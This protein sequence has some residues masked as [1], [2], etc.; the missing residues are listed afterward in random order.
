MRDSAQQR[1]ETSSACSQ[2]IDLTV[3]NLRS[4]FTDEGDTSVLGVLTQLF[5]PS[6]YSLRDRQF[7]SLRFHVWFLLSC[8]IGSEA[9]IGDELVGFKAKVQVCRNPKIDSS[10]RDLIQ[11]GIKSRSTY[12]AV[13]IGAGRLLV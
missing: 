1:S 7:D 10:V 5:D 9:D 3:D 11:L 13:D 6:L 4:R 2:L 12:P 8:G